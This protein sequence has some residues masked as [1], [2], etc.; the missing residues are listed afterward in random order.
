MFELHP[1]L[2][3]KICITHL[4]LSTV[5]LEDESHYPWIILVPRYTGAKR[6]LDLPFEV[7]VKLLEEINLIQNTLWEMFPLKQLNIAAIGNKTDQ[8]HIHVIGRR[9]DDPAWPGVVWDHPV[10]EPYTPEAKNQI[11][12]KLREHLNFRE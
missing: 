9:E 5:L 6:L 2:K 7:Q 8:L 12:S 4:P 3:H 10:R 11:I 1:N